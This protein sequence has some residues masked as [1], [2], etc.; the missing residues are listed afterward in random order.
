MLDIRPVFVGVIHIA[1]A[2]GI[3]LFVQHFDQRIVVIR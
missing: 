2:S 3:G 1:Q